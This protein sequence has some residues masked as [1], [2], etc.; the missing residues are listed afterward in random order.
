M[1][2]IKKILFPVDFSDSCFGAARH[3]EAMAGHFEAEVMFLHVVGRGEHNLA[4]ALLPSRQAQLD[5]FLA[6]EFKYFATQRL[7]V[8]GDDPAR[9]IVAT[10]RHWSPD[11]VM[12]PTQ[13]LGAFHRFLL[14]S[15]TAKV[16]HNLDCPVWTGVHSEEALPLEQIHCRRIMCSLDL[17]QRSQS[18][19][20]WAS[21]LA[22]QR[23]A[24]LGIVHATVALPAAFY[25][26]NLE[27]DLLQALSEQAERRIDLIQ[28]AAGTQAQVFIESGEP[29]AVVADAAVKFDANLLVA[30]R[31]SEVGADG[32]LRRNAYSILRS[33]PCPVISL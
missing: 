16:L 14:G 8:I 25:L 31:H 12:M 2:T 23:G 4:E 1:P 22:G 15:V 9:E 28:K 11:L 7:C 32:Y 27:Q 20:E 17:R 13:G 18:I 26:A 3:V 33:S 5:S 19:L 24:S 21:W 30:G 29:A 6:G 10:A